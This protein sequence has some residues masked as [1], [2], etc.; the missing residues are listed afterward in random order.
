MKVVRVDGND[1]VAVHEATKFAR[2]F[3][4]GEMSPVLI[5][6]MT[7]RIGHHS[8]S[9]DSSVYRSKSEI[10]T[11]A[12]DAPIPRLRKYLE[13]KGLWSA[14]KEETL[15]KESRNKVLE[16]IGKAENI[17]KPAMRNLFEDVYKKMPRHLESQLNSMK[18]HLEKHGKEYPISKFK[19]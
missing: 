18:Q 5:E 9:D 13:N 4:V 15:V 3:A 8:T 17:E 2:D 10:E 11:W 6:A 12:G 19:P 14:E 1:V 7:Y 16:V